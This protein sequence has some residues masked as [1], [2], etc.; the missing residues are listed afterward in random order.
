MKD[1]L[2]LKTK[3]NLVLNACDYYIIIT[4]LYSLTGILIPQGFISA[5]LHLLILLWTFYVGSQYLFFINKKAPKLINATS[6]LLWLYIVYG[7]IYFL[8]PVKFPFRDVDPK[9][10]LFISIKSLLPI[11]VF[12]R[13]SV[14]GMLKESHFKFYLVILLISSILK[15][16]KYRNEIIAE[17]LGIETEITN[18][19]G[20]VF[21]S[22]LPLILII[23]NKTIKLISFIVT[24][25]FIL[26]SFKRGAILITG[27][28]LTY[29][30]YN[31]YKNTKSLFNKIKIIVLILVLASIS[32][33]YIMDYYT[34]SLY[35]QERVEETMEGDSSGRDRLGEKILDKFFTNNILQYI[36]GRG[37][38]M[39]VDA[40]GNWAHNDWLET[41]Y[42]NGILGL[43]ILFYYYYSFFRTVKFLSPNID[44]NSK[45]S[46]QILFMICFIMTF[47]SMS[48]QDQELGKTIL[49]GYLCYKA[50]TLSLKKNKS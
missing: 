5:S 35:V 13:Y 42:C 17:S 28:C 10:Y 44:F 32:I 45:I 34:S 37:A 19:I 20:Y 15:Y 31:N 24:I 18:N 21:L 3:Y 25:L 47:F 43:I 38:N 16:Y 8:F 40:A 33:P 4:V 29:V 48:V 6:I 9:G 49:I 26:L 30:V 14:R 1:N 12:Y 50:E 36:F 23:K 22:L 27:I 39:T 7:I 11:L 46:F 2:L 41:I